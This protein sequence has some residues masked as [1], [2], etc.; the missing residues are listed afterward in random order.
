MCCYAHSGHFSDLVDHGLV[1][2]YPSIHYPCNL[3]ARFLNLFHSL[4]GLIFLTD[5]AFIIYII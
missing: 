3:D 2:D 1:K 5:Y 4:L